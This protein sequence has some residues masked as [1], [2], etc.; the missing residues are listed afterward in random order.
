MNNQIARQTSK[1]DSQSRPVSRA[2]YSTIM[3][4]P[5]SN[6]IH[7]LSQTFSKYVADLE[8]KDRKSVV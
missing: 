4:E 6:G 5:A 8:A 7:R 3:A 2:R 1:R